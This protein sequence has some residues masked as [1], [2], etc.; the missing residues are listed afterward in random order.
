MAALKDRSRSND[1]PFE[2]L[3]GSRAST[4]ATLRA[5]PLLRRSAQ[6]YSV[7]HALVA[8]V[9]EARITSGVVELR[10]RGERVASHVLTLR[11]GGFSTIAVHVEWTQRRLIHSGQE[12]GAATGVVVTVCSKSVA[13][14]NTATVPVSVC[15]CW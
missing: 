5:P 10:H 2:K 7:P 14:P 12:I 11:T 4:F 13:I 1:K 3:P 9:L 15:C 6:R 8:Q